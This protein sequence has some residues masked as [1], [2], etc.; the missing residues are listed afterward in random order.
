MIQ[1]NNE[2]QSLFSEKQAADYFG[3]SVYTMRE[4][5]KRGEILHLI[6]KNK[7]V[8]YTLEQLEEYKNEHISGGNQ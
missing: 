5:R 3:W 2:K 7:T 6:F 4:I 1:K 8:R